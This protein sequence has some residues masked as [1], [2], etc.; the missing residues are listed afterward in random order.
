MKIGLEQL[1]S[2]KLRSL[3]EE[4]KRT[5]VSKKA[6]PQSKQLSSLD[7]SGGLKVARAARMPANALADRSITKET[8]QVGDRKVPI[9]IIKPKNGESSGLYLNIP[10]GGFY[11]SE[12]VR[13]DVYNAW[14]A[15]NLGM[16][17]VSVDYRL[18]P[19]N[20][21]PAAPDDCHAAALWLIEY[22]KAPGQSRL[23][24]GG[25]SAGATLAT[26]T[27]LRLRDN[28][29]CK[30]FSGAIL[31]FG[32]YDLSGQTPSGKLYANEYF[33]QAYVGH[34]ADKTQ[35]DISPLFGNL[36][37]MPPILMVVG[38]TDILMEDTFA[39]A[40]RLSIAGNEIDLRV[41]PDARHGFTLGSTKMA[42]A[43][44]EDIVKWISGR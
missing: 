11:L 20:P 33:I 36:Q 35:A 5:S 21:W 18:G 8:A 15:D 37:D 22:A 23:V 24:I 34:V 29:S 1:I 39:M 42:A 44:N 12:A 25:L 3:T 26:T 4:T 9:R 2:P 14:L 38:T 16:T 28:G 17:V 31:Q 27:L 6:P 19:E 7:T 43:A 40:A 32:A 41:Y 10:G 13:N 30:A